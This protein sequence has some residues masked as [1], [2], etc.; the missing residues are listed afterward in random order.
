MIAQRSRF[1]FVKNAKSITAHYALYINV[2]A[3]A[4]RTIHTSIQSLA[5]LHKLYYNTHKKN[6]ASFAIQP[7]RDPSTHVITVTSVYVVNA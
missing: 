6:I 5:I 3:N 2:T 7:Q 1:S 4:P